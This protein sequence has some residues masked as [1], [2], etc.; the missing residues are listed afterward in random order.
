MSTANLSDY[1]TELVPDASK[2]R[3]GIVVSDWNHQ[4]TNSLLYGAVET[5][6]RHGASE[7]N[8]VINGFFRHLFYIMPAFAFIKKKC[9]NYYHVD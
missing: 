3:F 9:R 5:L 1:D 4:I 7:N 6:K 2:L 8:I